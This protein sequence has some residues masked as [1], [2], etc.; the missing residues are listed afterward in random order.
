MLS[1]LKA[2]DAFL[3]EA[4]GQF[5]SS[6]DF[7]SLFSSQAFCSSFTWWDFVSTWYLHRSAA[8]DASL[9]T[10]GVCLTQAGHKHTF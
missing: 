6:R 2:I 8:W 10:K 1:I 3:L 9:P 7:F 4:D 5:S